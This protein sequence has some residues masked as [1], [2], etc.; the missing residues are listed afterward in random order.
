MA[1]AADFAREQAPIWIGPE[2]YEHPLNFGEILIN[3]G[4]QDAPM[5]RQLID[6]WRERLAG[7]GLVVANAAPA[8]HIAA[9][10]LGIPSL[11]VSQGFHNPPPTMPSPPLRDWEPLPP[12]RLEEADR[13]VLAAINGALTAHGAPPL[14]TIG[15]LF[16]GRAMLRTY[17]E[18]DIYPQRGPA[19]YFGIPRSGE[20]SAVPPWPQGRGPRVFAYLYPYYSALARLLE[21]LHGLDYPTLMLCRGADAAL[22]ERHAMGPVHL[23][24]EPMAATRLLPEADIVVCHGSHQM[25]AQA[26]LAGKPL[27]LLPTQMEQF[28]TTR[29]VVRF[30]A[31]LGIAPGIPEADF[32]AALEELRDNGKYAGKAREF[33]SRYAGHDRDAALARIVQRCEAEL[34]GARA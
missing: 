15:E 30:G 14:G 2:R 16:A 12:G 1:G 32:R 34:A 24:A 19:D 5:L 23:A 25:T 28:L 9:R 21:T 11:E 27:L 3:S 18:L 10:T 7:T 20:G 13:S 6:A 17:P 33:A 26:L 4:Y 29:R 22:R 8:A 31:G